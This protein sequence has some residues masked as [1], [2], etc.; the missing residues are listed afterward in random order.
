MGLTTVQP[1]MTVCCPALYPSASESACR[2][3]VHYICYCTV[4]YNKTRH[5]RFL[6]IIISSLKQ[7]RLL[8]TFDALAEQQHALEDMTPQSATHKSKDK[9]ESLINSSIMLSDNVTSRKWQEHIF[10]EFMAKFVWYYDPSH[11]TA[12]IQP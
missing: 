3:H 8:R 6:L 12:T 10:P 7:L 11:R 5:S 1:V 9:Q 2:I 4:F